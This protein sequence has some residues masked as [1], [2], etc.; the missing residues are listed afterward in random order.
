MKTTKCAGCGAEIFFVEL[1]SGKYHPVDAEPVISDGTKL[2]YL[3]EL[4]GFKKLPE[5]RKGFESHFSTCPDAVKFRN[6]RK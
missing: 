2:L 4:K 3:D 1:K 5:G 6:G